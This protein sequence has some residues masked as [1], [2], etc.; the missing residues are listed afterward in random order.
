M[1]AAAHITSADVIVLSHDGEALSCAAKSCTGAGIETLKRWLDQSETDV[2]FL[3]NRRGTPVVLL[4]F[5]SW[6]R[7]ARTVVRGA[8]PND[9]LAR[10]IITGALPNSAPE[11]PPSTGYSP[12][13]R[14]R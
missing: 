11:E 3:S 12:L 9:V 13:A 14:V 4:S 6:N 2:L 1:P 7:V 10:A 5:D 8:I